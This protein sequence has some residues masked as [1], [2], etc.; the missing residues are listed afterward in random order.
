MRGSLAT[1][2]AVALGCYLGAGSDVVAQAKRNA[3]QCTTTH[4]AIDTTGADTVL[5]CMNSRGWGE[6]V[7]ATDT[8]V[9]SFTVWRTSPEFFIPYSA[10][11]FV[12]LVDSTAAPVTGSVIYLGPIVNGTFGDGVHPVPFVFQIDP[13]LALP[14]PG[15]Y[16]FNVSEATCM[17]QFWLL[18]D[19]TNRYP[20]GGAWH[21]GYNC[22]GYPGSVKN[23]FYPPLDLIFDVAFCSTTTPVRRQTWGNLKMLY[24]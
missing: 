2:I 7:E 8:L 13:P 5:F 4:V 23:P 15:R 20:P 21:T 24:R 19:S 17:G 22:D 12:E 10:R 3:V 18:A 6:V 14:G 1:C 11:L 9:E 16:Y